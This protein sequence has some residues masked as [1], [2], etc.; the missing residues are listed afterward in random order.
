MYLF[1]KSN[2]VTVGYVM[3]FMIHV[4]PCVHYEKFVTR[5]KYLFVFAWRRIIGKFKLY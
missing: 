1:N 3:K 5:V 2:E 4:V